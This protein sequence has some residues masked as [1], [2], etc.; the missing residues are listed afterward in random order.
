[1]KVLIVRPFPSLLDVRQNTYN[2]Q[3]VGLAKALSKRGCQVDL[4]FWTDQEE[5]DVTISVDGGTDVH[6][7]YRKAISALKNAWYKNIDSLAKQYD[8]IQ[9][10]EYN[11]IFSWHLAGKY[12]DKTIVYHGPY[13]CSFNKNYNRMCSMFDMLFL[14]RYKKKKICTAVSYG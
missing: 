12:P 3:E 10:A 2:I 4:L 1:M 14:N 11:Q 6:V 7:F 9:S 5:N 8:V 13:F